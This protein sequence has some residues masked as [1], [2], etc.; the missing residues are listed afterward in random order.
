MMRI[1]KFFT[2]GGNVFQL[3]EGTQGLQQKGIFS[4]IL[5]IF[6]HLEYME[7]RCME[8]QEKKK[9]NDWRG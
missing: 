6:S 1:K 7:E 9:G 4:T 8:L 5:I 3:F 2:W